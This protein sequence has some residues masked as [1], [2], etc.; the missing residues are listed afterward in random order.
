MKKAVIISVFSLLSIVPSGVV[1]GGV[2]PGGVGQ[3]PAVRHVRAPQASWHGD[4]LYVRFSS[5][6]AGKLRGVWSLHLVPMYISGKDTVRYPEVGYFT[7]S[8]VKYH[9]RREALSDRKSDCR[10]RIYRGRRAS[11]DYASWR[12]VP[13]SMGSGE[14][15]LHQRVRT[16]CAEYTLAVETVS[17]PARQVEVADTVYS[18]V[19]VAGSLPLPVAVVSVPLFEANVTFL[20]PKAEAVKSV[21]PRLPSASTIR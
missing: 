3:Y 5:D 19:E 8:G 18:T 17:V 1:F 2:V 15:Q 7:P 21:P 11:E 12:F 4:S 14:L 20:R 6:I 10:V 13:A 16:C 9:K